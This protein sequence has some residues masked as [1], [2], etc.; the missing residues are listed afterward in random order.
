VSTE[1][2][3]ALKHKT[4]DGEDEDEDSK[5]KLANQTDPTW[6]QSSWNR[7]HKTSGALFRIAEA[8][9]NVEQTET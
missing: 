9:L 7:Y 4:D 6:T 1:H 8:C 2:Q 5:Q 3:T